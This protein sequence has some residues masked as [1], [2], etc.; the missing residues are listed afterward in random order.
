MQKYEK[1]IQINLAKICVKAN[2]FEET[3]KIMKELILKDNSIQFSVEERDLLFDNWKNLINTRR[4]SWQ[5]VSE[6]EQNELNLG[7]FEKVKLVQ[8][9]RVKIEKELSEII[10]EI[11]GILDNYLIPNSILEESRVFYLKLKGDFYR[12]K[13]EFLREE[14]RKQASELG[15]KSYE[16]AREIAEQ[17]LHTSH[18]TRLSL[19]LN[20]SVFCYEILNHPD[21][22]QQIAKKAFDEAV[23]QMDSLSKKFYNDSN[24]ILQLLRDNLRFWSKKINVVDDF[25]PSND[26]SSNSNSDSDSDS[27]SN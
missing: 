9:L 7:N 6:I 11:F 26:E 24:L 8:E 20:Y 12:Y 14:E 5:I 22:A 3:V 17:V 15:L 10:N 16:K 21:Q 4:N 25:L 23:I 13:A 2:S 27:N 19:A 1:Q 18:P